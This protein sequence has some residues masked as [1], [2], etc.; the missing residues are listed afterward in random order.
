MEMR[1]KDPKDMALYFCKDMDDRKWGQELRHKFNKEH[2]K[3]WNHWFL[4]VQD[5]FICGKSVSNEL[6]PEY[7]YELVKIMRLLAETIEKIG[8]KFPC[9]YTCEKVW[10][11]GHFTEFNVK[12][13]YDGQ[14][15]ID[16]LIEGKNLKG[17]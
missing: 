12:Y 9:V 13:E 1:F 4:D 16:D 11:D 14:I 15:T 7:Q 8:I 6:L 5:K 10:A 2:Q 17:D 3:E